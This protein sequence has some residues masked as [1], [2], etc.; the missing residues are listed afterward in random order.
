MEKSPNRR[1][2]IVNTGVDTNV[3]SKNIDNQVFVFYVF[4]SHFC[5]NKVQT[6]IGNVC[7]GFCQHENSKEVKIFSVTVILYFE[8]VMKL[9][10]RN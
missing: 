9:W 2:F 6:F 7:S 10:L 3:L 4:S 5:E 1:K 8:N